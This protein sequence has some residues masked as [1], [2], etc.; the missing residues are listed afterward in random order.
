MERTGLGYE[1]HGTVFAGGSRP[2]GDGP[3]WGGADLM[4]SDSVM[5]STVYVRRA[6][7]EPQSGGSADDETNQEWSG[8]AM[9][10]LLTRHRLTRHRLRHRRTRTAATLL[11][12]A[13][14]A[15]GVAALRPALASAASGPASARVAAAPACA[16]PQPG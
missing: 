14:L 5:S 8:G 12:G 2:N 7:H 6:P 11:T 15:L 10:Y 9:T 4:S 3:S 16:P 1:P 13:S